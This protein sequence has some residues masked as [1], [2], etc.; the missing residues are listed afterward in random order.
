MRLR[1]A[2]VGLGAAVA[3][4]ALPASPY[5]R[6]ME[7]KRHAA[8]DADIRMLCPDRA[9]EDTKACMLQKRAQVSPACIRLIDASE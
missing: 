8:C 6:T 2:S 7:E 1:L 3:V 4:A 5:A 9:P